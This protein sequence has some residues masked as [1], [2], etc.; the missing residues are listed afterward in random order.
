MRFDKRLSGLDKRLFKMDNP[1]FG[2]LSFGFMMAYIGWG[3]GSYRQDAVIGTVF[4][5]LSLI[6]GIAERRDK[7]NGTGLLGGGFLMEKIA[8]LRYIEEHPGTFQNEHPETIKGTD[9]DVR[10]LKKCGEQLAAIRL[11]CELHPG[12]SSQ[13]ADRTVR[14]L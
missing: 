6:F 11:Y 9:D 13:D 10:R 1:L 4:I 3:I 8:F 5:A 2:L 7:R 14:A 12:V